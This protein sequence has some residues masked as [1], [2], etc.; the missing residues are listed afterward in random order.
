MPIKPTSTQG[1]G[2]H[3]LKSRHSCP[4]AIDDSGPLFL[5]RLL[6]NRDAIQRTAFHCLCTAHTHILYGEK[7][8]SRQEGRTWIACETSNASSLRA[9]YLI[10]KKEYQVARLGFYHSQLYLSKR[11]AKYGCF[12]KFMKRIYC[13]LKANCYL[14]LGTSWG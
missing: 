2:V 1:V 3:R 5:S 12:L 13:V 14:L 10:W 7:Q 6:S 11:A 4:L 8:L 9:S